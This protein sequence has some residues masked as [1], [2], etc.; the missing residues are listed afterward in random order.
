MHLSSRF[1]VWHNCGLLNTRKVEKMNKRALKV[2]FRDRTSSCKDLLSKSDRPMLYAHH[3]KLMAVQTFKILN[4]MGIPI[5][6]QYYTIKSCGYSLRDPTR[7]VLLR[8]NTV[9]YGQ[10]SFNYQ[11]YFTVE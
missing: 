1:I 8:F 3:R 6:P 10:K 5:E 11:E 2:V 7:L 9:H 4:S